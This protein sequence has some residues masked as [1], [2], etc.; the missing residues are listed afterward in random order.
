VALTGDERRR[1]QELTRQLRRDRRLIAHSM[2]FLVVSGWRR[3]MA[4]ARAGTA[5][6][7][8]TWLPATLTA[9]TGLIL[10]GAGEY[11]HNGNVVLAGAWVLIITLI[12]AGTALIVMGTADW[13][14]ER[15]RSRSSRDQGSRL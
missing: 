5:I 1:W 6:P 2:R 3:D 7:A 12:L 9:C 11:Y 10:V 8:I 15:R 4:N 14:D 13:R